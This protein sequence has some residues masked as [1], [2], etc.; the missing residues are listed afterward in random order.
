MAVPPTSSPVSL[1]KLPAKPDLNQLK[2]QAKE[3]ARD[4]RASDP[5]ALKLVQNFFT[6]SDDGN[7]SLSQSQL[8]LARSYGFDSW[9]K[10]KAFVD[11]VTVGRLF[12]AVRALDH[13]V[14]KNMLDRRPELVNATGDGKGK[15]ERSLI[16]W[17]ILKDDS[18]LLRILMDAGA[19]AH[20][21][22]W[23]HRE[24]TD[25]YTMA[26]ER[27]L[28]HLVAI[29]DESERHRRESMSCPNVTISEQL[30]ELNTLIRDI[31]NDQAI[32]MMEADPDLIKQCNHE[33]GSPLHVAC[34]VGK[35]FRWERC[36]VGQPH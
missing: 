16:H 15:G 9:P 19:D 22:I 34:S 17:A 7:L 14:V 18:T 26:K 12:D 27:G 28:D 31:K 36:S 25:A 6:P 11:G 13:A 2:K 33:G 35:T 32:R 21:G 29:I 8:A 23:P 3:L 5:V 20:N 1:Q 4:Y 30:D 24:A 10:L